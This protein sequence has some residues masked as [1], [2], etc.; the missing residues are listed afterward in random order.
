MNFQLTLLQDILFQSDKIY[1]VLAVILVMFGAIL[2]MM[3]RQDR[4]LSQMEA[5][6]N[7]K[8]TSHS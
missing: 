1:S 7:E 3:I 2:F 4:K 5:E 6:M 8:D